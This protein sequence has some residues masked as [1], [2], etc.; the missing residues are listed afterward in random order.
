LLRAGG[1]LRMHRL[2]GLSKLSN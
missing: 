2:T 1:I